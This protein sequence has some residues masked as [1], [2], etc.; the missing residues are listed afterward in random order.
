MNPHGVPEAFRARFLSRE[1]THI[2]FAEIG[3]GMRKL[4]EHHAVE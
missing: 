2:R 1:G 4:G 3:L